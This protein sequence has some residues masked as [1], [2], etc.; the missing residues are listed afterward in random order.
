MRRR[1]IT[2]LGN[3]RGKVRRSTICLLGLAVLLVGVA[4]VSAP[5]AVRASERS[6]GPEIDRDL[7]GCNDERSGDPL[8]PRFPGC[9]VAFHQGSHSTAPAPTAAEA[10]VCA[11][12]PLA[13]DQCE[14]WISIH[15]PSGYALTM[16]MAAAPA[17]CAPTPPEPAD[18]GRVFTTGW[19]EVGGVSAYGTVAY[20]AATGTQL[21]SAVYRSGAWDEVYDIGAS[22]DGDRVFITGRCCGG[23]AGG[24]QFATIAYDAATGERL[25]ASRHDGADPAVTDLALSLDVAPDGSRVYVT[26]VSGRNAHTIAYDAGT[27]AKAWSSSYDGPEGGVDQGF[28]VVASPDG[29]RVFVGGGSSAGGGTS[30]YNY[31]VLSYAA[32]PNPN[33]EI[34]EGDQIWATRFDNGIGG[35]D[36]AQ[37]LAVS[38]DGRHVF[39]SGI[40]RATGLTAGG[41]Y[42]NHEF[43]TIG[44]DA[45]T[46]NVD[47]ASRYAGGAGGLNG[48]N[49]IAVAPNGG[50]VYVTGPSTTETNAMEIDMVTLA[51]DAQTGQQAWVGRLDTPGH[52]IELGNRVGVS[53]DS[54]RVFTSGSSLGVQPNTVLR[55]DTVTLAYDAATGAQ[56][57]AARHNTSPAA[58]DTSFAGYLAVAADGEHVYTAG[59]SLVK[60]FGAVFSTMAYPTKG[61]LDDLG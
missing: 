40:A 52:W 7:I 20:D 43:L 49:D 48:A 54:S 11:P 18:C 21:W 24:W 58:I 15:D 36:V 26:G 16:G 32:R 55:A 51:Y 29:E 59:M 39:A 25:W 17:P 34:E 46:G 53:P 31:L 27:G 38:A 14:T 35:T 44:V 60:G 45:Y 33:G 19:E 22:A 9:S 4:P 13:D 8:M 3:G 41:L 47:W 50:R 61:L 57:W 10:P 23:P 1:S 5:T 6:S 37:T 42:A 12:I 28:E 56:K 30:N 2:V